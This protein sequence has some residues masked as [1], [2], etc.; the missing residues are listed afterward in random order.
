MRKVVTTLIFLISGFLSLG[1]EMWGITGSNY[2]GSN[3]TLVNP[4]LLHSSKMYFDINLISAD[5]FVENSYLFIPGKDFSP[6]LY[7]QNDAELPTYGRKDQSFDH[8]TE[9]GKYGAYSN[10]MIKG[11][12]AMLIYNQHA[13]AFHTAVRTV[14]AGTNV[15][16]DIA[17]F[18]SESIDYYPQW[19]INYDDYDFQMGAL[20][21]GEIGLSYAYNFYAYGFDRWTAGATVKLLLGY[22]G[23]YLDVNNLNYL[24]INDST[25]DIHNLNAEAGFSLPLDTDN[26]DFP[27]GPSIK[28]SGVAMDLG[29]T[30]TKTK[31]VHSTKKY[32]QLCRQPYNDYIYRIGLS[33]IDFGGMTFRNN[34]QKHAYDNVSHYWPQ[35]DTMG[36]SNVNALAAELSNRFYGDPDASFVSD[37]VKMNLP[38][39]VGLQFDYHYFEN[40]YIGAAAVYPILLNNSYL[41]RPAQLAV[42]PRYES[43]DFE[44]AMPLSLYEFT[45]PRI[46]LSARFYFFTIGTDKLGSFLGFGDFTGTDL[47]FSLKLNFGK[48]S[49]KQRGA[50]CEGAVYGNY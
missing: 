11:P 28:G 48:G 7:L 32:R 36:Y 16:Y 17:N 49:C 2:A 5:V 34:A 21:W 19:N 43:V 20:S 3:S 1:Q 31:R 46:G 42:I 13:F 24:I 22:S 37:H 8:Y 35:I 14:V 26:N 15:P 10:I 45:R 40:W 33:V 12:S 41:R 30:Y 4:S 18:A 47:Y 23:G 27:A 6:G 50:T 39:A 25:A 44:V 38:S 29:I 9:K